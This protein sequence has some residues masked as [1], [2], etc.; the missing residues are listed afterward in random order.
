MCLVLRGKLRAYSQASTHDDKSTQS[1]R[2]EK[3]EPLATEPPQLALSG[4][5]TESL[6]H[7][8]PAAAH[9]CP[10]CAHS[11]PLDPH[12][13]CSL[14]H[15]SP[16]AQSYCNDSPGSHPIVLKE[17][18]LEVVE[19]PDWGDCMVETAILSSWKDFQASQEGKRA[20]RLLCG[21][22]GIQILQ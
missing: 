2:R 19:F 4:K 22:L 17:T 1:F 5:P 18:S 10:H 13:G 16:R 21:S 20:L 11:E 15:F 12:A 3:D 6:K 14:Q 7:G 9:R 8:V